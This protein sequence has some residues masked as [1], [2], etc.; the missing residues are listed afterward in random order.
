MPRKNNVDSASEAGSQKSKKRVTSKKKLEVLKPTEEG[1]VQI[2]AR[3]EVDH[4]EIHSDAVSAAPAAGVAAISSSAPIGE[5]LEASVAKPEDS[6]PPTSM[7]DI[8]PKS[9]GFSKDSFPFSNASAERDFLA[10]DKFGFNLKAGN[11]GMPEQKAKSR[12]VVVLTY[13]LIG[14]VVLAGLALYFLNSYSQN[15]LSQSTLNVNVPAAAPSTQTPAAAPVSSAPKMALVNVA[16]QAQTLMSTAAAKVPQTLTLDA[17]GSTALTGLS[18]TTDTLYIKSQNAA[19][20]QAVQDFLKQF[21]I[22]PQIQQKTDMADDYALYLTSSLSSLSLTGLTS[23]V[24]NSGSTGGIAGKYCAILKKYKVASCNP[25]NS[26]VKQNIFTVATNN[27]G[28]IVNLSRTP[29]FKAASF[30]PA[31]SGQVEN[32]RVTTSK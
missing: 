32:I 2:P 16:A 6:K 29:E 20:T 5:L 24:Y 22:V 19:Q 30:V 18:A 23:A 4:F 12:W 9:S 31:A 15:L 14:V 8:K 27:S 7:K 26:T 3:D 17:R 25:L 28:A 21:G 11:S 13:C 1:I 10:P